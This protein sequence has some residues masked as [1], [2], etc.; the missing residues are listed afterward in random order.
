[1]TGGAARFCIPI[2]MFCIPGSG[3]VPLVFSS[4]VS[5]VFRCVAYS[6]TKLFTSNA[7]FIELVFAEIQI[8]VSFI[9]PHT[10]ILQI[11]LHIPHGHFGEQIR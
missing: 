8:R 2:L 11:F 3:L 1:M 7:L 10:Q 4:P 6:Q 9:P 5:T